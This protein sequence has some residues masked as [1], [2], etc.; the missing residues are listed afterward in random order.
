MQHEAAGARA[1]PIRTRTR[2]REYAST[3]TCGWV[4]AG[5]ARALSGPLAAAGLVLALAEKK[6]QNQGQNRGERTSQEAEAAIERHARYCPVACL[7]LRGQRRSRACEK[8]LRR[9]LSA[10]GGAFVTPAR[11]AAHS[12][13]ARTPDRTPEGDTRTPVARRITRSISRLG[14]AEVTNG[15]PH[16]APLSLFRSSPR[17]H[18][19]IDADCTAAS[20]QTH[21]RPRVCVDTPV[22]DGQVRQG[23]PQ[24]EL[25]RLHARRTE[26]VNG[27]KRGRGA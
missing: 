2:S 3:R 11:S 15:R 21:H 4:V 19:G 18:G 13:E 20:S 5:R 16:L 6:G 14:H 10:A 17:L 23:Q 8:P 12:P 1:T 27:E 7:V 9:I 25:A 24:M 26:N 22:G